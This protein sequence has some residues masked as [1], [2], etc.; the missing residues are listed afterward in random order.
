MFNQGLLDEADMKQFN[1]LEERVLHEIT[2]VQQEAD[3]IVEGWGENIWRE[4]MSFYH[5]KIKPQREQQLKMQQQ[6]QQG[7]EGEGKEGGQPQ[8]QSQPGPV[9]GPMPGPVRKKGIQGVFGARNNM[10]TTVAPSQQQP[11]TE[12]PQTEQ[13]QKKSKKPKQSMRKRRG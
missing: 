8:Q 4:A 13:P 11:Q 3:E 12:Q 5:Q 6:Q 9:Q 10:P 2:L 1:K 7:G